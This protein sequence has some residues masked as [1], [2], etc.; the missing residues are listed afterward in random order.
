MK[1]NIIT[2]ISIIC[3]ALTLAVNAS[4]K[5]QDHTYSSAVTLNIEASNLTY[6]VT[7]LDNNKYLIE[8]K[9]NGPIL[10]NDK[11]VIK[12]KSSKQITTNE[13][14]VVDWYK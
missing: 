14:I 9:T 10:V 6:K 1:K 4:A 2:F 12:G 5:V 8:N 3:I 13:T 11:I 7:K